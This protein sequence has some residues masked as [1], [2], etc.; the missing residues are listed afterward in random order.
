MSDIRPHLWLRLHFALGARQGLAKRLFRHFR[1]IERIFGSS[2]PDLMAVEG[3][4]EPQCRAL[5][6][7]ALIPVAE[8]ELARLQAASYHLLCFEDQHYPT[9]LF[10]IYDPPPVL[11]VNGAI[12]LHR[13]LTVAIV[14]TRQPTRYG[15][16]V[17]QRL[18][19][20]LSEVGTTIVSGFALGI[21]A[22]AHRGAITGKGGTVAVLGCGLNVVYPRQNQSLIEPITETG[23]IISEFSLDS[24]PLPF[25]F[26]L[27]NRIISGLSRGIVVIEADPRSG[28]LITAKWGIEHGREIFAVPGNITSDLSRGPHLLIK[29]GAK[30]VEQVDDILEEFT[31]LFSLPPVSRPASMSS[32]SPV[33]TKQLNEPQKKVF[34]LL[35]ETPLH[36]DEIAS[37]LGATVEKIGNI[38]LELELDGYVTQL[39]GKLFIRQNIS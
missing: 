7:P 11:F 4:S 19:G 31:R 10:D 20:Q 36:I 29:Q 25:H 17:A 9:Q 23:A 26:P 37:Q 38:L 24:E 22:A 27:R 12:P 34:D 32:F 30:L 15:L 14:G 2:C 1:S 28:S 35:T 16:D 13:A 5:L 3:M 18:A 39:P 33:I 6:N 8:Q 21:D